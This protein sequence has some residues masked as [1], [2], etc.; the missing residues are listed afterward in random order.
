[1][2]AGEMTWEIVKMFQRNDL[3]PAR[4]VEKINRQLTHAE[5]VERMAKLVRVFEH[6]DGGSYYYTVRAE[7]R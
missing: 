4:E 7:K 6:H 5:M 1:M 2:T 3:S